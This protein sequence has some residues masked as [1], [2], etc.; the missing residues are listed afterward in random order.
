MGST[1][2]HAHSES[3]SISYAMGWI[4]LRA[5]ITIFGTEQQLDHGAK[6]HIHILEQV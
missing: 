3:Y 4:I 6:L 2:A 1:P 5:K